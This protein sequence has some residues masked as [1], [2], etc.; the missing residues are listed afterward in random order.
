MTLNDLGKEI[1]DW[2][3]DQGFYERPYNFVEH[4]MLMVSEASE[5]LEEVRA[6]HALDEIYFKNGKPE[7]VPTE[8]ADIIIR[9]LDSM[10]HLG[11]NIDEVVRMKIEHNKTRARMNGGKRL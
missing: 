6:G 11:I 3:V 10:H 9:V 7:G 2:A 1:H 4:L 5:A 8:L